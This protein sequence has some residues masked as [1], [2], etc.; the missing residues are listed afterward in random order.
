MIQDEHIKQA[1]DGLSIG[2]IFATLVGWLPTIAAIASLMWSLI[3]IYETKTVQK[4]LRKPNA[5]L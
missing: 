3:R 5:K 4:F 1:I 2:T